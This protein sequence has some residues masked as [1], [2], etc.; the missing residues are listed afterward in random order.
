V[1]AANLN[2]AL[3][4]VFATIVFTAFVV[5]YS[6]RANWWWP[7]ASDPHGEHRA[8]L[9]Y[10]TASLA[11]ICWVYDFR[12]LFDP[13]VFAWIRSGLFWLIALGGAWRLWL[14]VRPARPRLTEVPSS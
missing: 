4:L 1:N 8:H 9:G 14:L 11:L 10:F 12:P 13:A 2:G 7:P 3:A 5:I 6:F